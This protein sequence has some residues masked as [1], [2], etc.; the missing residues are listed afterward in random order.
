MVLL[1]AGVDPGDSLRRQNWRKL[2]LV[3]ESQVPLA[4]SQS[5]WSRTS[6]QTWVPA[7]EEV[8]TQVGVVIKVDVATLAEVATQVGVVI[9]QVERVEAL[10][11]TRRADIGALRLVSVELERC[12]CC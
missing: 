9:H 10:A 12:C 1:E 7:V 2:N 5:T 8:A 3:L 6:G 4:K 11:G